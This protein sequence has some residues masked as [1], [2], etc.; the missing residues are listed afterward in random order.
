[1]SET[2]F[3]HD[4]HLI[5]PSRVSNMKKT[6]FAL[7]VLTFSL[8]IPAD[9]FAQDSRS[10]SRRT[11]IP[12]P[13]LYAFPDKPGETPLAEVRKSMLEKYDTDKDGFLSKIERNSMR[14]AT[15]KFSDTRH[16]EIRRA[17]ERRG[18]SREESPSKPPE[19]WLSLYDKNKNGRFDGDEWNNARRIEI[20]RVTKRYDSNNNEKI[21]D[22]E[23]ERII[24]NLKKNNYNPYDN[25]IRAT[26]AGQREERTGSLGVRRSRWKEFDTNG[27]GKASRSELDAIRKHESQTQEKP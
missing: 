6:F 14:L 15:K 11:S 1:M 16:D 13:F 26:I 12:R 7:T 25:Y 3:P 2:L 18:G 23:K 27:D 4:A 9:L 5:K 21:D 22:E 10:K 17:R 19:R 8:N 20:K 24:N